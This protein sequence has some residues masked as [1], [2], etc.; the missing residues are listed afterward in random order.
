MPETSNSMQNTTDTSG[1]RVKLPPVVPP[2]TFHAWVVKH[3]PKLLF[4]CVLFIAGFFILLL[5]FSSDKS[6][7]WAD[8]AKK[9]YVVSCVGLGVGL[10]LALVFGVGALVPQ[11]GSTSGAA[12]HQYATPEEFL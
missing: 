4:L 3:A 2:S 8:K 12:A 11:K 1:G 6:L 9:I 10:A 5:V 7:Q